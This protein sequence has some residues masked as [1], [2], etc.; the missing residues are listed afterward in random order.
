MP[1][2][3]KLMLNQKIPSGTYKFLPEGDLVLVS[4]ECTVSLQSVL[5]DSLSAA[6]EIYNPDQFPEVGS[7]TERQ[8][9]KST[10]LV[11]YAAEYGYS[12][13]VLKGDLVYKTAIWGDGNFAENV[14]VYRRAKGDKSR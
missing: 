9:G 13:F 11:A 6:L 5:G 8:V 4:A 12:L 3:G 2:V 14:G 1:H 7:Y 10:K